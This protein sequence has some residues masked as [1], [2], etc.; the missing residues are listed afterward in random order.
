MSKHDCTKC[1]HAKQVAEHEW[2]CLAENYDI[3]EF[4]CFIPKEESQT[5]DE[6]NK[7]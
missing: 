6:K 5:M 2:E 1:I 7:D 3:K 4:T